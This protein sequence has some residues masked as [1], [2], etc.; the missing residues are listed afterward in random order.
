MDRKLNHAGVS[1]SCCYRFVCVFIHLLS[2]IVW[3]VTYSTS[4]G[5][6]VVLFSAY[7]LLLLLLLLLPTPHLGRFGTGHTAV[8][9]SRFIFDYPKHHL[10]FTF[11]PF[12]LSAFPH[13]FPLFC[14]L[15]VRAWIPGP[16]RN[17]S[18]I[19]SFRIEK[20]TV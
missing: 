4:T 19:P 14:I 18:I 2:G 8:S 1:L 17:F 12:L 5:S 3:G 16:S 9:D 7:H 20:A 13:S 11:L 15:L 10:P 6:E